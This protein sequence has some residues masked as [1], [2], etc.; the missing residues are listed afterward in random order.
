MQLLTILPSASMVG[1]SLGVLLTGVA[2][3]FGEGEPLLQK[4]LPGP[5]SSALRTTPL[6]IGNWGSSE[7]SLSRAAAMFMASPLTKDDTDSESVKEQ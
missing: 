4:P 1:F 7:D 6:D 2:R 3:A 5:A